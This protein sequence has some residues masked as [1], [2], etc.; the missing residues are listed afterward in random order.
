MEMIG[1]GAEGRFDLEALAS[2]LREALRDGAKQGWAEIE[3]FIQDHGDDPLLSAKALGTRETLRRSA[4]ENFEHE[5]YYLIRAAAAQLGIFGNVAKEALY[6]L[7]LTD[8]DDEL[9]DASQS[10]YTMTFEP[11]ELP[12]VRGFWSLSMYDDKM[13]FVD[14]P[15]DRYLL[16]SRMLDQGQLDF[17]DDG[18]LTFYISADSPGSDSPKHGRESNWLPAPDGPFRMILRMY[19][20][21]EEAQRGE[22]TPPRP[23]KTE[24]VRAER[25][26]RL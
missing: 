20:P 11:G 1:L 7:F 21:S 16:N 5:N 17:D 9:L 4:R 23:Q 10:D 18:S 13:L 19:G 12:P 26:P 15:L 22:W 3:R 24:S 25:R 8:A 6:P 2:E 14:N